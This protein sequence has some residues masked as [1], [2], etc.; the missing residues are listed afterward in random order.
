MSRVFNPE[1]YRDSTRKVVVV[2]AGPGAGKSSLIEGAMTSTDLANQKLIL[3]RYYVTREPR[4]DRLEPNYNF[5]T[6][7]EF[8]KAWTAGK[9]FERVRYNGKLYGSQSPDA[10]FDNADLN[11]SDRALIVYDLDIK[12]GV[13]ALLDNCPEALFIAIRTFQDRAQEEPLL[14]E[15][16]LGR[17]TPIDEINERL[18]DYYETQKPLL[19]EGASDIQ[20][21]IIIE[22][23]GEFAVVQTTF[24]YAIINGSQQR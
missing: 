21:D 9:M 7:E 11:E 2:A 1:E 15:R 14:I 23:L 18:R 17:G 8:E 12:E 4:E 13:P 20:P 24:N 16:M 10:V 3:P 5:V 6:E 19:F 22:N